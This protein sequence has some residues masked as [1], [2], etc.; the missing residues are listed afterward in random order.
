MSFFPCVS[1]RFY[2]F[3]CVEATLVLGV[4]VTARRVFNYTVFFALPNLAARCGM[5]LPSS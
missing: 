5:S 4:A 1:Q 2:Q 3:G